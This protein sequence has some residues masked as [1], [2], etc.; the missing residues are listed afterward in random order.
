MQYTDK[1]LEHFTNPRNIGEILDADGVGNAGS[2]E[3]GDT[4]RVWIKVENEHLVDVKYRV[5]G[6]PAAVA[7][8]SIMTELAMGKHVDEAAELTDDQV[9][10]ALGGLPEQKYHCSNLAA[11][12]LYDAIMSYALKSNRQDKMLSLSVLVENTATEGFLS[13]HGLSFWIEYNSKRI[14]FDTGQSNL[15]LQ[16]A[17]ALNINLS[18]TDAIV[19]SHGHYD[20]TGG[21]KTV[22]DEAPDA[23]IY[24]HPDA[25]KVRYSCKHGKPPRQISMPQECCLSLSDAVPKG[26]V[27]YTEKPERIY[28]GVM[29]TGAIP[30]VIEYEDTGGAFYENPEGT[31]TDRITDDQALLIETPQGLVVILGCAHSGVV[32]TLRYAVKL[33]GQ[34]HINAVIGGMHLLYAS[35]ERMKKTIEA[36]KHYDVQ[37]IGLAH[38]TGSKAAGKFKHAFP[39][40]CFVCSAGT[41][42]DS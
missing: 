19:L 33:T 16:N 38:C 8:C 30:R 27:V 31:I 4:L 18:Q 11:S 13:E 17:E 6:C 2:Q 22:L 29:V 34:D 25:P 40:Q 28:P 41:R 10:E 12:A 7:C 9:A 3:C 37:K 35:D 23:M 32:N 5:F 24:L 14:L 42:I 1:V 26:K 15:I 20:H 36:M 21:L 39:E